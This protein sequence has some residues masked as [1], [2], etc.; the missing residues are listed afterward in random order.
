MKNLGPRIDLIPR[1]GQLLTKDA[2]TDLANGLNTESRA[3]PDDDG[4]TYEVRAAVR[5]GFYTVFVLDET[6]HELGP[7]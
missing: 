6:G 7:L 2:A 1:T 4:W 5:A 3:D